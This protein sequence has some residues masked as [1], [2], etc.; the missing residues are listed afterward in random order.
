MV[1]NENLARGVRVNIADAGNERSS[2]VEAIIEANPGEGFRSPRNDPT[3]TA[4]ARLAR[5][6]T[7]RGA[8]RSRSKKRTTPRS[9]ADEATRLSSPPPTTTTTC[10]ERPEC[11]YVLFLSSFTYFT[12][13]SRVVLPDVFDLFVQLS[14]LHVLRRDLFTVILHLALRV[15]EV[16]LDLR[17]VVVFHVREHLHAE[18]L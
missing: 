1:A 13:R 7:A 9:I 2:A 11:P 18:F 8:R 17:A 15:R 12:I 14:N 5:F 4:A 6:S 16:L 3:T 10:D